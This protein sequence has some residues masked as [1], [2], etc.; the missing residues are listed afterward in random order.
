MI[1]APEA[2]EMLIDIPV[3]ARVFTGDLAIPKGAK[4]LVVFADG[5]ESSRESPKNKFLASV[6]KN[7]GMGTLL[8]DLLAERETKVREVRTNVGLLTHRLEAVT[9][10]LRSEPDLSGLL[11]GYYGSRT[12]AAVA[13]GAASDLGETIAAVV[14]RGGR[15][16]LAIPDLGSVTAPTLFIV[17]GLDADAIESNRRAYAGVMGEKEL[18]LIPGATHLFEEPGVPEELAR[19]ASEWFTRHLLTPDR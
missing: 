6:L 8:V 9:L 15:P 17:P 1:I 18:H 13:L 12:G 11:L 14:L 10:W 4:G 3:D 5:A 19:L 2:E 7:D 16:D